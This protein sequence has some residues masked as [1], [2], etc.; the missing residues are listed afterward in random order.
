[1]ERAVQPQVFLDMNKMMLETRSDSLISITTARL[2][3]QRCTRSSRGCWWW[4]CHCS[5]PTWPHGCFRHHWP[6]MEQ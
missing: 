3:W 4:W 2:V 1:L 6:W 5:I